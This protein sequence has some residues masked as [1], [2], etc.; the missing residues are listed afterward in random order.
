MLNGKTVLIT[1]VTGVWGFVS[2]RLVQK[3]VREEGVKVRVLAPQ[4]RDASRV[5]RYPVEIVEGSITDADALERALRGCH[6]VVHTA[7]DEYNLSRNFVVLRRLAEACLRHRIERFVDVSSFAVYEPLPDGDVDELYVAEPRGWPGPD[8]KRALERQLLRYVKEAGLPAVMVELCIVYGPF[9]DFWT[10]LATRKL[11]TGW[12]VLPDDGDGLCSAVYVDDVVQAIMLAATA[13]ETAVGERFLI[14]G[15]APVT[16]RQYYERLEQL[17]GVRSVVLLPRETIV[18]L[19]QAGEAAPR[20]AGPHHLPLRVLRRQP[21][22]DL[23]L[24]A[25]R[26]IGE[27]FWQKAR[28]CLPRQWYLPDAKTLAIYEAKA[29]I[30]SE[31]ARRLLGYEPQFDFERGMALT[32]KYI[33]WAK[34]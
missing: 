16:W 9:S 29:T 25:R 28:E 30:S 24:F 20:L 26:R 32:A 21:I 8:N 33:K 31:K 23:Y 19:T 5:A 4:V 11:R 10:E 3:L 12:V 18:R 14:A 2:V 27:P 6:I 22:A 17:L 13:A 34:L 15:P 1:G 7:Y